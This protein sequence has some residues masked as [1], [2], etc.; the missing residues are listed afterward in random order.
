MVKCE[1][2]GKTV[3]PDECGILRTIC[4]ACIDEQDAYISGLGDTDEVI[5]EDIE[6]EDEKDMQ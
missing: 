6:C 3:S 5:E 2:C 1:K 4:K